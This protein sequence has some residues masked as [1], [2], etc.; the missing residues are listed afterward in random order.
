MLIKLFQSL[1]FAFGLAALLLVFAPARASVR[2]APLDSWSVLPGNGLNGPVYAMVRHGTDLYVAGHF[3]RT[4]D[5]TVTE[6]SGV[7]RWDGS[8][9]H[10]LDLGLSGSVYAIAFDSAGNLYAGGQIQGTCSNSF[11]GGIGTAFSN[12]A[13]WNGTAWSGVGDG[14]DGYVNALAVDT[15]D[16]VYIGGNFTHVCTPS[17][18]SGTV[19]NHVAKWNGS[20]LSG[21]SFGLNDQVYALALDNSGNLYAGGEFYGKCADAAC[22]FNSSLFVRQIGKWDGSSWS[23]LPSD[24]LNGA[25]K[26]LLMDGS[27]LY[28]GGRFT[29]S[30]DGNTLN[31]NHV[32][33]FSSNTWSALPNAGLDGEVDELFMEGSN[34]NTSSGQPL[35]VGGNFTQTND[36][37][38]TGL[39]QVA[40]LSGGTWSGMPKGGLGPT[41]DP[42][43]AFGVLNSTLYVGGEFLE[44]ADTTLTLFYIATLGSGCGKPDAPILT[45]P[46]NG[47]KFKTLTP[48]LKWNTAACADTYTVMVKN[49]ATGKKVQ[50]KA[51]LTA[52]QFKTKT[53]VHGVTYKWYV[54]GCN[55]NGCTQSATWTFKVK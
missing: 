33:K 47:K 43:R 15:G 2:A 5:A 23:S 26:T 50:K 30:G 40:K 13:K 53:L 49:N 3:S 51:G 42:V 22:T 45:A 27:D 46:G 36:T 25:V 6:L 8:A 21:L 28:A 32:A 11:C 41:L 17:C 31:L 55:T 35:Y 19:V 39:N 10:S 34:P 44:T 9:W 1:L 14:V 16:N 4:Q 29:Q 38:V 7:A 12:L 24:G 48:T 54:Q 37:N 20:A 18:G 52:L